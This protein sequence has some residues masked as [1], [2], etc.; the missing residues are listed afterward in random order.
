MKGHVVTLE[1][2][3]EYQRQPI[4]QETLDRILSP[5]IFFI[6]VSN[7]EQLFLTCLVIQM[8]P[9]VS[10]S[11][12]IGFWIQ[13]SG[14]WNYHLNVFLSLCLHVTWQPGW[15]LG[16]RVVRLGSLFWALQVWKKWNVLSPL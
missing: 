9:L 7:L 13:L 1:S 15:Q 4:D 2:V 10:K 5:E 8:A 6:S 14:S 16:C 12:G 3:P 11:W